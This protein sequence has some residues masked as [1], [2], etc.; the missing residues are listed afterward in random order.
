VLLEPMALEIE[1]LA[2]SDATRLHLRGEM[3]AATADL[4]VVEAE[5]LIVRGHNRLILD[6]SDLTFC[7]SYG[8]RAMTAL[9]ERVHPDGTV[10][11]ARPSVTLARMLDFTRLAERFEI[12]TQAD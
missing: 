8:L 6:C 10:T 12:V 7:D 9:S 5:T 11:I 3:D 2:E 4:L 1:V